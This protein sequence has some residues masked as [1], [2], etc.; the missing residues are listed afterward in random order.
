[1]FL[2]LLKNID[3]GY[4]LEPPRR[5]GS[6]GYPQPMFWANAWKL[7][8]FFIWKFSFFGGKILNIFDQNHCYLM[9]SPTLCKDL[10]IIDRAMRKKKSS[11]CG[12][13]RPRS[14]C[15]SAQS[16]LGLRCSLTQSFNTTKAR[17]EICACAG[18]FLRM[19]EGV[20]FSFHAAHCVSDISPS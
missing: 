8:E 7:P 3:C 11:I 2:F 9:N 19:F 1:M 20:S 17:M 15:A 4:S 5:G 16:D 6:N 18:W 12:Q 10:I 14:D 13:R